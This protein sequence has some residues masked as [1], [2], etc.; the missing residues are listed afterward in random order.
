MAMLSLKN[1][2]KCHVILLMSIV[3]ISSSFGQSSFQFKE[4]SFSAE[5]ICDLTT[6]SV[7][8]NGWEVSNSYNGA[9][10][11]YRAK[12][13]IDG[14]NG[15]KIRGRIEIWFDIS[16]NWSL[17]N[18][19]GRLS[20]DVRA[21]VPEKIRSI[22]VKINDLPR[23]ELMTVRSVENLIER[24]NTA[25]C[26]TMDAQVCAL[27]VDEQWLSIG[28]REFPVPYWTANFT[29]VENG[30]QL[31]LTTS[32]Q[33][34]HE[35]EWFNTNAYHL[36]WYSTLDELADSHRY[37]TIEMKQGLVP[38]EKRSDVAPWMKNIRLWVILSGRA[39]KRAE[40]YIEGL[41]MRHNYAQ[42]KDRLVE[43][44]KYFD[45]KKT[46]VYVTG[47]DSFYDCTPPRYVVD[48]E[49]GGEKG[50]NEFIQTAHKMG[51]HIILHFDPWAVAVSQP[52]YWDVFEG[53][54]ISYNP[55]FGHG[56]YEQMRTTNFTSLDYEPWM[57]IFLDRIE[58]AVTKY[59]ADGIHMDQTHLVYYLGWSNSQKFDNRRGF[60]RVMY[61][62]KEKFPQLLLQFELPNEAS[63]ALSQIG[64]NPTAYT[65][66]QMPND[67]GELPLLFKKLYFPYI[68]VVAHLSTS[69][70]HGEAGTV[71]G[72][73]S[74][75]VADERLDYMKH[76]DFIPTLKIA[77]SKIDL[78]SP[79]AQQYFNAAKEFDRRIESGE[80]DFKF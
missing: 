11:I 62:I 35:R 30:L 22:Q 26:S 16:E 63:L 51:Y 72:P 53:S 38:F 29:V 74:Q 34:A 21:H 44:A 54:W 41:Y 58:K 46:A 59:G 43:I 6:Y 67:K 28:S 68:R 69:G 57:N 55:R 48:P 79:K 78:S 75:K 1:N 32:L 80:L 50:W 42:M 20:F 23:G 31:V 65:P 49:M 37:E 8:E 2:L 10:V 56:S 73:V 17:Q 12:E 4:L 24:G 5:V 27:K 61:S 45:P 25:Y 60:Y 13:I 76:N 7:S 15:E 77:D 3:F 18:K 66:W 19:N 40:P 52:E 36:I 47:W 9:D 70:P 71:F 14:F 64:E 33:R 39:W